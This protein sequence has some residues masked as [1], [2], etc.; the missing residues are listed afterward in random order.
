M[1][2]NDAFVG[3]VMGGLQRYH[4][5]HGVAADELRMIMPI[6]VRGERGRARRATTSPPRA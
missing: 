3:G 6:N 4:E 5:E 2:L 1:S